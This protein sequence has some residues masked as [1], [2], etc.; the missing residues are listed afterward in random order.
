M[1]RRYF[2]K[3][4]PFL[5]LSPGYSIPDI[6]RPPKEIKFPVGTEIRCPKCEAIQGVANKDIAYGSEIT[7]KDWDGIKAGSTMKSSCC[8]QPY[9]QGNKKLYTQWGWYG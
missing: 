3:L 5:G 6:Y 8:G 4:L 2:V 7:S 1:L 9:V